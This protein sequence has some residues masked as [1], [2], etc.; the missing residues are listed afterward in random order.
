MRV[1]SHFRRSTCASAIASAVVLW[2]GSTGSTQVSAAEQIEEFVTTGTRIARDGF[3]APTPVSV[4]NEDEIQAVSANSISEFVMQM[5]QIT[6]STGTSTSGALSNGGAGISSLSARGLG[7]GRT[8]VLFDGQRSVVSSSEGAVDTNTFP[9]DLVTRVE[10]AT[11]GASAS[12][13]SDAVAGVIN[14]ILDKTF[15]GV[16]TTLDYGQSMEGINKANRFVLSA[17]SPWAN[18]NGHALFSMETF[19]KDGTHNY[20]PDWNAKG[21]FGIINPYEKTI[22]G[23][24]HYIVDYNIGISAYTPGGLITAGPLRGTYFGPGGSVHQLNYGAVSGQWMQGGDWQYTSSGM[25]GTTSFAADD[26]RDSVFTRLSYDINA[27]LNVFV[28]AS[29]SQYEGYSFYIN[30]TQTGIRIMADN[31]FLP[32]EV[33]DQMNE[34]GLTSFTMGTSNY[35]M[36]ASGSNNKRDTTRFVLG[37][38]GAIDFWG[39][40]WDWDSYYQ[41]GV[42]NT[43]EHM[44]PTFNFDR[45][46]LA[47]DAVFHPDTGEIVCRIKLTQPDHPCKPL[48]RMGIGVAS[49]EGLDYVMGR[50]RREQEFTQNVVAFNL[51]TSELFEGWAGPISLALGGEHRKEEMDGDVDPIWESGWKYG[52]YKVTAGEYDVSEVYVETLV[53]LMQNLE[54]NS[55]VRYT[56]Y[57]TSGEVTTWKLGLVYSPIPSLT[58]RATKSRDIRAANMSELFAAG[59]ARTNNVNIN[60]QSISFVQNLMGNPNVKPEEADA[61]G[62]GI[63]VRPEFLPGLG[64]SLDYW[65]VEL[66]GQIGFVGAQDVA[67]YC[68]EQN[69][70]RYC[71]D[72]HYDAN[73]VLQTIDL[74][75]ENLDGQRIKGIDMEVSYSMPLGPGD[76]RLRGMLTHN[77]ERVSDDGVIRVDT[78]GQFGGSTASF[79]YRVTANYTMDDWK[80]NLIGRGISSGTYS[81]QYIECAVNC[82]PSS[83]P[84]WTI[85]NNHIPSAWY[86]DGNV[87]KEMTL[88]GDVQTEFFLTI[89]NLLDKEPDLIDNPSGQGSENNVGGVQTVWHDIYG[90]SFR[91]GVRAQF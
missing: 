4:M 86:F 40:S 27:N 41:L 46:A 32:P 60:G 56:D 33:R 52:N 16:K 47:Q 42:T 30:P 22:P 67:N 43:D 90:R 75:Y 7:A 10:M 51:S 89:T 14:F 3:D 87:A 24:P 74:R 53:P 9:Q 5:P 71:N 44:T 58:L 11:G 79:I 39:R 17:G 70:Q 63:V 69:I 13:G 19:K 8:L 73:G 1:S 85:N 35:D 84:N 72:M 83:A 18:G 38:N 23:A 28:Q 59:T 2:I 34:L 12:Y 21:F 29:Y 45:I 66:S 20:N 61:I 76:L 81:N 54:L 80:F 49:K 50:P 31:A 26:A 88:F 77:I 25:V 82:P 15:T 78:A 37:A 6:G 64:I 36:P 55:A 91:L 48:N 57:S 62:L 65:D 68:F